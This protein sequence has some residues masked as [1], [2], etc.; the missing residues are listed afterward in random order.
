MACLYFFCTH[1]IRNKEQTGKKKL[2]NDVCSHP[3]ES[4]KK[5]NTA[6]IPY[7]I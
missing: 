3:K 2:V 6:S 4:K 1:F 5:K 7:S